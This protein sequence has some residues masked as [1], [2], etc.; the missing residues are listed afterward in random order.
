MRTAIKMKIKAD[1][2]N[3]ARREEA[4]KMAQEYFDM[5]LIP[6]IEDRAADGAYHL[7]SPRLANVEMEN[8]VFAMIKQNGFKLED[9]DIYNYTISWKEVGYDD[10]NAF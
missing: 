5:E 3:R 9:N 10:E 4:H 1:E 6:K 7:I 2:A 8:F